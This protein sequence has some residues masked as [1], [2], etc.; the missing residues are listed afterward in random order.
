MEKVKGKD[1]LDFLFSIEILTEAQS[2]NI[3][4][5]ILKAL[6]HMNSYHLCHRD[7]K[8]ENIMINPETFQIKL[9][10]FGFSSFYNSRELMHTQ[11]G[12][13]YYITK[14]QF[15]WYFKLNI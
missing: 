8:L 11:V 5:Q 1:L 15:N 3:I 7:I 2:A 13:P 10:D 9:I 6:N 12:T 14:I 4:K